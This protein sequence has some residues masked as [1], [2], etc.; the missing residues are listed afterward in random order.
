MID[1]KEQSQEAYKF[2]TQQTLIKCK[3]D[4]LLMWAQKKKLN[5]VLLESCW[6]I[7]KA[8]NY[9]RGDVGMVTLDYLAM[10]LPS[11]NKSNSDYEPKDVSRYIQWS[12]KIKNRFGTKKLNQVIDTIMEG[13][14]CS[15]DSFEEI[16]KEY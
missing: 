6:G 8:I 10:D 9:L 14:Y 7:R 4:P 1:L 11:G 13:G 16:I 2:A 3:P 5:N 12:E 15:L